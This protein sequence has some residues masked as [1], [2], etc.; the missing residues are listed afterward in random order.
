MRKDVLGIA[1]LS[2]AIL[3]AGSAVAAEVYVGHGINGKDLGLPMNLAVDVSVNGTCLLT[4][5]KFGEFAGPLDL[6]KGSYNVAVGLS[7]GACGQDAV[8][9]GTFKLRKNDR[10]TILA[11][12]TDGFAPTATAFDNDVQGLRSGFGRFEVRHAAAAPVVDVTV[13]RSQGGDRELI[14]DGIANGDQKGAALF[15]RNWKAAIFPTLAE[16]SVAGPIEVDLEQNAAT[17]VYAVG[18]LE[19]GTFDLLVQVLPLGH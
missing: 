11:H 19:N 9:E 18:S 4:N 2:L 5:F 10:V 17:L 13:G 1:I 7:D 14:L 15:G 6:P 12:L 8:I 3:G 16:S